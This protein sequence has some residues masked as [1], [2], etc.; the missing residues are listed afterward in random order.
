MNSNYWFKNKLAKSTYL[1]AKTVSQN[2]TTFQ[3]SNMYKSCVCVCVMNSPVATAKPIYVRMPFS[4]W[5]RPKQRV[6][7]RSTHTHTHMEWKRKMNFLMHRHLFG[8]HTFY[9]ER[10]TSSRAQSIFGCVILS[11]YMCWEGKFGE[12]SLHFIWFE[13]R[14][15]ILWLWQF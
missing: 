5:L 10:P 4:I 9:V 1:Y 14:L 3:A 6:K 7:W 15:K 13:T 2:V 8:W 11:V 12:N